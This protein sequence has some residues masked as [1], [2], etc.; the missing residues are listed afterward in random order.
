MYDSTCGSWS[1]QNSEKRLKEKF[2]NRTGKT[3]NRFAAENSYTWNITYNTESIAVW[4]LIPERWGSPLVQEKY[5][6]EITCDDDDDDDN[7]DDDDDDN[8]NNNNNNNKP[9]ILIKLYWWCKVPFIMNHLNWVLWKCVRNSDYTSTEP[10]QMKWFCNGLTPATSQQSKCKHA[11][12]CR[13]AQLAEMCLRTHCPI[14]LYW[15]SV[16]LH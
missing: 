12:F 8:N 4:N 3:F 14:S 15:W 5:Q 1:H 9:K 16:V 7:N 6:G 10:V 13:A 2:R 11:F